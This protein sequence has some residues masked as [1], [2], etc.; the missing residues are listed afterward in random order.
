VVAFGTVL[1]NQART[2]PLARES[3]RESPFKLGTL[4]HCPPSAGRAKASDNNGFE[5]VNPVIATGPKDPISRAL[6]A[7]GRRFESCRPD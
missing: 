7:L 6:G 4:R 5:P 2:T 1:G 3:A